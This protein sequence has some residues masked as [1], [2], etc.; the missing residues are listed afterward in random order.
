[1]DTELAAEIR[2]K[3]TAPM[4]ALEKVACGEEV[5]QHFVEMAIKELDKIVELLKDYP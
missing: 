2:N 5:P 4:T 1:M 3:L